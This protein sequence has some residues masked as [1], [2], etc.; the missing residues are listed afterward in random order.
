M[1]TQ[2]QQLL[3]EAGTT[4]PELHLFHRSQQLLS[5]HNPWVQRSLYKIL[6]DRGIQVHLGETVTQV[7]SLGDLPPLEVAC[8]SGLTVPCDRL[9]WVTQAAAPA[10]L[11]ASGLMVDP[12]GFIWVQD[13]LQSV[14]HPQV[15]AA[16]DIA[17]LVNRPCPKSGVFAVR[18]GKPLFDNLRCLLTGKPLRPYRPQQQALS[19]I[20][21]GTQGRSPLVSSPMAVA[22]WGGWGWGPSTALW[23]WKDWVDRRFM[24]QFPVS[25]PQNQGLDLQP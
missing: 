22:S 23:C 8:E 2:L 3:P 25:H 17:T 1:Q 15:L 19:L 7:N 11:G 18:Q 5:H 4:Q 9:F 24:A 13:T 21:I 12:L 14:S 20:G 6:C 16:G 10:W